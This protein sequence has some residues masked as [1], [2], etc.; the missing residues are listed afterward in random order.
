MKINSN[1]SKEEGTAMKN[2]AKMISAVF[3]AQ[4]AMGGCVLC[5]CAGADGGNACG[6]A[7]SFLLLSTGMWKKE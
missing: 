3:A 4:K 7:G 1:L 2:D 6:T 5:V